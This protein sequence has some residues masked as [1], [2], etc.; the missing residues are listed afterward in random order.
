MVSATNILK[1]LENAVL[2]IL[3]RFTISTKLAV[4]KR[5]VVRPLKL[6]PLS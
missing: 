1:S 6:D 3:M 4:K 2:A 5:G